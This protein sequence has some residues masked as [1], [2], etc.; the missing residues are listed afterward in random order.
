M[1]IHIW[2]LDGEVVEANDA[3]LRLVDYS[4]DD[5]FSGQVRW[6]DLTPVEWRT[7]DEQALSELKSTGTF[8]PFEKE[9]VRRDGT[10]VPVLIGGAIFET[11]GSEGV[12][13]IIDLTEQKRAE[14]ALRRSEAYL[15][16][17]Q[18][19]SHTGSFGWNTSTNELTW[20]AETFRIFECD[21]STKVTL[22]TVLKHIYPEDR[23]LVKQVLERAS[24]GQDDWELEHRL[25]MPDGRVKYVHVVAHAVEDRKGDREFTG[26]VR[27]ITNSKLAESKLRESELNL[28]EM[29]E[30]I[31]EMLWS[32]RSDGAIDYCN[33]R[34][35]DYTG[36]SAAE[37]M[38]DGWIKLIHPDDVEQAGRAWVSSIATGVPYRVEV[39]T[40]HV[41]D[42]TY[43]WCVTRALP[44]LDQQG[45][46]LKWHGTVVDM[47]DWKRAQEDLR[48]T[49]ANLARISR[50][51]TVGELTAS[52]AHE[53]NQPLGAVVNNANACLTILANDSPH[54]EEVRQ[55]LEEIIGGA[56]RASAVISRVRSLSKKMPYENTLVNLDDIVADVMSF[57]RHEAASRQVN[58][59][60]NTVADLPSVRGDRVQL[61]Q[62]LLNLV[63]NG[64][65]A[66]ATI[67]PSKRTLII[68]GQRELRGEEPWYLMSIQDAGIGVTR[69]EVGRLFEAFYTTKPEGMGMG[70]AIS[71]SIIEAHGGQLWLDPEEEAGTTFQFRLPAERGAKP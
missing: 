19:L 32:A 15:A 66:M 22:E 54:L 21:P 43:R 53:V 55:A 62:V 14:E 39:R 24:H 51:T 36:F 47:H 3:F 7:R 27:D 30:T 59:Q 5:L 11:N 2:R 67:E 45:R 52:I 13:F 20:S 23:L 49:Q 44:L 63:I 57:V 10:R 71:R 61:Q 34:L 28:R 60:V 64:M 1:G 38:G 35:L 6:R 68:S 70:L 58:I 65:E 42:R 8:K 12:A 18:R 41:A 56:D 69:N 26:A 50:L 33:T 46:I 48:N 37:V 17:A 4:R 9:Y 16:E 29:T 40:F 31:P 25:L